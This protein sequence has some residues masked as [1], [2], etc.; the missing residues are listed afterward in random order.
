MIIPTTDQTEHINPLPVRP[1]S[2]PREPEPFTDEALA[3]V[4]QR[5]H[6]RL[7]AAKRGMADRYILKGYNP[8]VRT[9]E[10]PTT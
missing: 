1:S 3:G 5:T 6:E 9:L 7:E 4:R 2:A 8:V 10:Q